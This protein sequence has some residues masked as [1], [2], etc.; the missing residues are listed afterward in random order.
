[1]PI[2]FKLRS[3]K[4][5]NFLLPTQQGVFIFQNAFLKDDIKIKI[6]MQQGAFIFHVAKPQ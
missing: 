3:K 1:L 2:I 4:G 6:R 5:V